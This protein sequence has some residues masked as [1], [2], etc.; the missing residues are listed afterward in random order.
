VI[1]LPAIWLS[2]QPIWLEGGALWLKTALLTV[3]IIASV[4]LYCFIQV[5]LKSEE[6][7][8]LLGLMKVKIS[9]YTKK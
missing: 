7:N 2:A 1:I 4:I 9:R 8:F 6:L 3:A 5:F